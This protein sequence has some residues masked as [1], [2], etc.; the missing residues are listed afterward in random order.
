MAPCFVSLAPFSSRAAVDTRRCSTSSR[1]VFSSSFVRRVAVVPPTPQKR[2]AP[3]NMVAARSEKIGVAVLGATGSVGQRFM[4]LLDNHPWF[5][6]KALG[7]SPR[8]A[9]KKYSDAVSWKQA[10]PIPG[11][12]ADIVVSEC[13]PDDPAFDDVKIVFSGLD[14]TFAGDVE[15]AFAKAGRAVFSNAKSHRMDPDVPILIPPVNLSHLDMIPIQRKNRGY[16]S[17]FIITNANCSTTAMAIGIKPIMEKFGIEKVIVSTMQAISGAG[18]PGLSGMDI[19]D[20]VVPFIGSE[21]EK[22]QTESKK[23]FGAVGDGSFVP[24]E[25][26]ISAMC[27]RVHVLDG[28]TECLSLKLRSQA[29]PE[30]VVNAIKSYPSITSDLGL[31]SAPQHDIVYH[32]AKDRPQPRMDRMVGNGYTVTVGRVRECNVFDVRLVVFG[33]NTIVGAAGGSL[34][35][36]ELCV[37]KGYIN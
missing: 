4:Q 26:N 8:S 23:I 27:N 12:M 13:T 24:A 15:D 11:Q 16:D 20:N 19:L 33:H 3:W 29:T 21:E 9:G 2:S 25:F 1:P 5:E 18:Y 17:G 31:P 14:A 32:P 22:M 36:A 37:Q 34:L 28:H 10:V 6:V 30:D 35:N 7:A